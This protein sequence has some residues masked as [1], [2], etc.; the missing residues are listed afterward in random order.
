MNKAKA[1]TKMILDRLNKKGE[2]KSN[3]NSNQ[4][5]QATPSDPYHDPKL[6][7]DIF[8]IN[9]AIYHEPVILKT[10]RK[11]VKRPL[12]YELSKMQYRHTSNS[13]SQRNS[14]ERL[15]T[16]P[17]TSAFIAEETK[18]SKEGVRINDNRSGM[19]M[20]K[21]EE[22][23]VS[24]KGNCSNLPRYKSLKTL[25]SNTANPFN[26]Q[27]VTISNHRRILISPNTLRPI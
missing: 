7:F 26:P 2:E 17:T 23:V 19:S 8:E 4:K 11:Q 10:P 13:Q 6:F 22:R 3:T 9:C 18:R 1:Y 20:K 24:T 12:F 16:M 14:K 5:T 21:I 27:L 25:P 15:S